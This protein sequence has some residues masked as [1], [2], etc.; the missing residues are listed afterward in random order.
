MDYLSNVEASQLDFI[1]GKQLDKSL[2]VKNTEYEMNSE[3]LIEVRN[4]KKDRSGLVFSGFSVQGDLVLNNVLRVEKELDM[5][6]MEFIGE[7]AEKYLGVEVSMLEPNFNIC[8]YEYL[9]IHGV[10]ELLIMCLE[11]LSVSLEDRKAEM[12]VQ[13]IGDF[14][15]V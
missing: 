13:K 9:R 5:K 6:D 4:L 8:L 11:G 15:E 3:L 14:F 7:I 2:E 1:I 10:D 12:L